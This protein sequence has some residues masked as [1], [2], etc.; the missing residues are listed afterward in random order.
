MFM[1]FQLAPLF[2]GFLISFTGDILL[3]RDNYN[4]GL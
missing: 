2:L 3:I 4:A 1:H